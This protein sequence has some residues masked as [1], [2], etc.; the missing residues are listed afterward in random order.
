V[1]PAAA[2]DVFDP[3]LG[4][5]LETGSRA[6]ILVPC[7]AKDPGSDREA[8]FASGR[9][10]TRFGVGH[11]VPPAAYAGAAATEATRSGCR[12][13]DAM[14]TKWSNSYTLLGDGSPHRG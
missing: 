3:K 10:L 2:P 11:R 13:A 8:L 9:V 6:R 1:D 4:E 12:L 14:Y 7:L 5:H